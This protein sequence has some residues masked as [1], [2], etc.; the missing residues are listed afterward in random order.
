[1]L[2]GLRDLRILTFG[3]CGSVWRSSGSAEY[4][5]LCSDRGTV[6]ILFVLPAHTCS[7]TSVPER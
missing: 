4:A 6:L 5:V 7:L 3:I 1:M 2:G